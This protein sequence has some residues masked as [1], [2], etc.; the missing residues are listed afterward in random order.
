MRL[1]KFDR[2]KLN[3]LKSNVIKLNKLKVKVK[4]V[5]DKTKIRRA[6]RLKSKIDSVLDTLENA[7]D[8]K[9]INK[10]MSLV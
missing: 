4:D 3:T 8:I 1:N 6:K 9:L 2:L 10:I 5:Y 7:L